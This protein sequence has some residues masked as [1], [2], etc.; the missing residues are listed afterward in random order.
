MVLDANI[1]DG[2]LDSESSDL[3]TMIGHPTAPIRETLARIAAESD[4]Q[5]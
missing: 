4:G 1:R 3:R 2:L 5:A